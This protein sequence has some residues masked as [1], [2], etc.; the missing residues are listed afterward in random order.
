[1]IRQSIHDTQLWRQG[2]SSPPI[3][4]LKKQWLLLVFNINV[5]SLS[6]ELNHINLLSIYIETVSLRVV[7]EVNFIYLVCDSVVSR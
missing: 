3:L 6:K 4:E 2:N 5:V 7:L 1:M